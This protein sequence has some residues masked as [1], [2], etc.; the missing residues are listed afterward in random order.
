MDLS[1]AKIQPITR[2]S[3]ALVN[4]STNGIMAMVHLFQ[5]TMAIAK[6]L[7]LFS[8]QDENLNL[9]TDVTSAFAHNPG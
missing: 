3:S 8:G 4:P 5:R 2:L 7:S 1:T 6:H 9:E